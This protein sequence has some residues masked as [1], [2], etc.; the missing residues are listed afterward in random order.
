MVDFY[1]QFLTDAFDC[2]KDV[3]QRAQHPPITLTL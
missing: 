2:K 3:A 1:A